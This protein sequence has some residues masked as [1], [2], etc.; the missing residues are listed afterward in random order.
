M[1]HSQRTSNMNLNKAATK[2]IK[3]LKITKGIEDPSHCQE[4]CIILWYSVTYCYNC[5]TN[6][7]VGSIW[8]EWPK[9]FFCLGSLW[10]GNKNIVN[11]KICFKAGWVIHSSTIKVQWNIFIEINLLHSI[12]NCTAHLSLLYWSP[13]YGY[14]PC[15]DM[16]IFCIYSKQRICSFHPVCVPLSRQCNL[17]PC[18]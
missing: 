7:M 3:S 14:V 10:L 1:L 18:I 17:V 4:N 6:M 9:F 8:T 15:T 2:T 16:L 12:V 5:I 11:K 13:Q